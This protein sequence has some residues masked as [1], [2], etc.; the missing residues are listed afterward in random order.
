MPVL[1]RNWPLNQQRLIEQAELETTSLMDY[2]ARVRSAL[3]HFTLEEKRQALEMLNITVTWHPEWPRPTL[4]E[5]ASGD[6]C[7]CL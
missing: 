2:C 7:D 5:S 6:F 3:Q 1:S 4:K